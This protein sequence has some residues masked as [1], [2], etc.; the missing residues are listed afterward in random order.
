MFDLHLEF[1]VVFVDLLVLDSLEDR[2]LGY[3]DV[4]DRPQREDITLGLNMDALGKVDDLRCDVA[5]G[6][7]AKKKIGGYV[8]IGGQTEVHDD[9]AQSAFSNHDILWFDVA[10]HNPVFVDVGE[11]LQ[12]ALHDS[13]DLLSQE[14]AP[15][16]L[17]CLEECFSLEQF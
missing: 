4:E 5:G 15:L 13:P 12:K 10:M 14:G 6:A 16:G 17:Y 3:E 9:W 8:Y 2:H 7:T 11:P 1:L